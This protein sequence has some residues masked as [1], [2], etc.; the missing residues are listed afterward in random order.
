MTDTD[1]K[2]DSPIAK[3]VRLFPKGDIS[4][5]GRLREVVSLLHRSLGAV[6][7]SEPAFTQG[8]IDDDCVGSRIVG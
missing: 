2:R 1:F 5:T 6:K 3:A 8:Q 7:K 4:M